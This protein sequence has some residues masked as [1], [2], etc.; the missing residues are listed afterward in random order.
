MSQPPKQAT[1]DS[2][3]VSVG[4]EDRDR[5]AEHIRLAL[6]QRMQ[7]DRRSLDE[8]AFEHVALP[9]ID[10]EDVDTSVDFLGRTLSAPILISCMTGGTDEA[11]RINR[12]LALGADDRAAEA[13]IDLAT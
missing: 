2:A 9:E 7:F 11:T 12:N 13:V 4:G 3:A 8:W 1:V 10:L 5:K 6:E